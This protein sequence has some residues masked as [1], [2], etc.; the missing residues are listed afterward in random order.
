[1]WRLHMEYIDIFNIPKHIVVFPDV[2]IE[3]YRLEVAPDIGTCQALL[4]NL[5]ARY[6]LTF[7]SKDTDRRYQHAPW[8]NGVTNAPPI[9]MFITVNL[10]EQFFKKIVWRRDA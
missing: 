9:D 5:S 7:I 6:F 3:V 10:F 8:S 1:M 4:A 2:K